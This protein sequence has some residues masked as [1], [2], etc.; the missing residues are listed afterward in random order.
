MGGVWNGQDAPPVP[1]DDTIGHDGTVRLR[2][3]KT[4]TGHQ[5]QFVEEDKGSQ[6]KAGTYV[7]TAGG[8]HL[9]M[10]DGDRTII[11]DTPAHHQAILD[12]KHQRLELKTPQGHSFAM[13]DG[14]RDISLQSTGSISITA[15]NRMTFAVGTNRI[16]LTTSGITIQSGSA[17]TIQAP[18][19]T[20]NGTSAANVT[21]STVSVQGSL[22]RIG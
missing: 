1:I 7:E 15:P 13:K 22:I 8:H 10:N 6:S 16:E 19:A 5:L 18:T 20:V 14:P 3:F 17:V 12:D 21:G 9:Q 11:L 4:R 2:T